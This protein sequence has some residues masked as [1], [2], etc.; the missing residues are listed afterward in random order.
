MKQGKLPSLIIFMAITIV[1]LM[2]A[3]AVST[4]I[5]NVEAMH[6]N[7]LR[8]RMQ[9]LEEELAIMPDYTL[10]VV[11]SRT[12]E[13]NGYRYIITIE[14][15]PNQTVSVFSEQLFSVN[16]VVLVIEPIEGVI[17]LLDLD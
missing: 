15:A 17:Y 7:R 13:S 3:L 14:G 1:V 8:L 6:N 4:A 11:Q 5:Y 12:P 16:D 10:A 9:A 2:F